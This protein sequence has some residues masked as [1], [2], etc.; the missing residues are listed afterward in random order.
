MSSFP[1]LVDIDL[2]GNHILNVELQNLAAH[3]SSKQRGFI[4]Y[5]TAL[6]TPF[7]LS[8]ALASGDA[9]DIWL[10]CGKGITNLALGTRTSTTVQITSSTGAA[11]VL[12]L[13]DATYAGL[14]SAA[15]KIRF[16]ALV[17]STGAEID[18]GTD[19]TKYVT[20]KGIRDSGLINTAI[21]GEIAGVTGKTTPVDGDVFLIEDSAATNAK[22]SL[23]LGNIRALW[24]A[25]ITAHKTAAGDHT[26]SVITNV[27][28]G[29]IV[30]V[31]VQ[32]AITELDT[33]KLAVS[34]KASVS[35]IDTGTEDAHYVTS[36][37]IR[38]SGI[39]S[40]AAS[41]EYAGQ[42][43]SSG[44]P[45]DSFLIEDTAAAGVKKKLLLS[46][47]TTLWTATINTLIGTHKG[48]AGDHTASVITNVPAGNI[49]ATTVQ[50]AL[51]E[52][53]SEK[54]SRIETDASG[55]GFVSTATDLGA[56]AASNTKLSTQLA[57]KTYIDNAITTADVLHL[58]GPLDCST[59][60]NFPAANK[61]DAYK[62]SVAGKIGGAAGTVVRVG[63][64]LTCWTDGQ[65]AGTLAAV[66]ANWTIQESD[67]DQA[68]E[69]TIGFARLATQAE[70]NTGTDDLTIITPLKLKT[71]LAT[72]S[73]AR[74]TAKILFG[75]A[76]LLT[77]PITHNL[78]IKEVQTKIFFAATD[79]EVGCKVTNTS[80]TQIT[81][82]VN[83]A[84][85]VNALYAIC[86]G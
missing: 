1:F 69:T 43:V 24:V 74:K 70:A 72:Y 53:D 14:L 55:Y 12:G 7:V 49:A 48:A 13:A 50:A 56:G 22:K 39:L 73:Y 44:L 27:P 40:T 19:D 26:A 78:G 33:N 38:G 71:N 32:A 18:T 65:V 60:P 30:A 47:I 2:N 3:P 8:D 57:V 31:T 67:F 16:D 21:S 86:I 41:G 25:A 23:T 9:S 46:A 82:D 62:V 28:A 85:G 17:K 77:Y 37:G 80:T 81:V 63:E 15:D 59:N 64:V 6:K 5:N 4:Y 34:Q 75:D 29:S 76:V 79:Q 10:D 45:G 61:G 68:T 20:T 83:V 36:L 54:I 35:D 52:L 58:V 42:G 84:P 51:N 11:V 66:G